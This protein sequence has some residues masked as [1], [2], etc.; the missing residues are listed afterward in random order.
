MKKPWLKFFGVL[1]LCALPA[2]VWAGGS[3]LN[4]VVVVNQA[5]SNSVQLGNYYC[6]Q[7]QVPPQNL[8]R[9]NWTGGNTSWQFSDFTNT[10]LN[11]LLA[12]LAANQLTNQIAY[13]VLCMDIPFAVSSPASATLN[14]TTSSLFYGFKPDAVSDFTECNLAA[15]S[16][17]LYAGSE[18]IF[19]L[20]PPLAD[21]SNFFLTTMITGTNLAGAEMVVNQGVASDSTFPTQTV[22]LA[23]SDDEARNVRF[24]LFD[25]AIFNTRLRGNYSLARTNLDVVADLG[26]LSG[27]QSGLTDFAVV[28][29][30]FAPGSLA[31][32][33]TSYG[34]VI[35]DDNTGQLNMLA[36]L[37]AGAAG[38]YGTVDEPCNFLQKFPIPQDYFWQARGFSLAEC[39]YMSVTNP[40]QGLLVGEPLAAPF[41]QPGTGNWTNLSANALLSATTNL[42]VQFLASDALHPLQQ[43]D[44]FV[45]GTF[46]ETLTNIPPA[47]GNKLY[48]TINGFTTNY[49]VP[50]GAT[51]L[52]VASNLTL[53]LNGLSYSNATKVCATAYGDRIELHSMNLATPGSQVSIAVSNSP[54]TASALTTHASVSRTSFLD[55][56]A[57]GIQYYELENTSTNVPVGDYLQLSVTKTNG[58]VVSVSVTNTVSGA[59]FGTL[60]QD[61]VN[62]I[63]AS[64]SLEAPDGLTAVDYTTIYAP[65]Y[66]FNLVAN[67]AGWNAAQIQATLSG[68]PIFAFDPSGPQTLTANLGDLQPRDHLYLTAGVTNLPLTFAFNTAA[69]AGGFHELTAVAYEGSHV[70]AQ[71]PATHSVQIQSGT[72]SATLTT[73]YGGSNAVVG[74]TLQFSVVAN[75]MGTIQLFSTGGLLA[76]ATNQSSA[77]FVVPGTNPDVGL[78]PVYAMVTT[79]GGQQ[80]RTQTQWIRLVDTEDSPFRLSMA[81][82]PALSWPAIAGRTYDIL[83]TTNL[84]QAFQ[85]SAAVTPSNNAAQWTETNHAALRR[86]YR[87]QTAD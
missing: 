65:I 40:Y 73:L 27:C 19:Q 29:D 63:N 32:N 54:G 1:A 43:I 87:V 14:S 22:Y 48:V 2:C 16:T 17:N 56:I 68:S 21:G 49:T 74:A 79:T 58:T 47:A 31:D 62:A 38:T 28:G 60:V 80:Y 10:L 5:S 61:L 51:I 46:A 59:S 30:D 55:T 20:T 42:S 7:R 76:G 41:A 37:Q 84:T 8:L 85:F 72:L 45:D 25:N 11:P 70:R 23:K 3:G 82:P 67:S 44:L 53:T 12:M 77:L 66:P 15:D 86:F 83:S 34:G 57:S 81:N 4:V 50:S 36:F 24:V 39:Y 78:H 64:P 26:P 18:S 69:Q 33:L 52:S 6:E 75:A 71:T 35:F 9:I 13:V